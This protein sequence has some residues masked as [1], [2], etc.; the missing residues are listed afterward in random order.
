M[1][2]QDVQVESKES[3]EPIN[4]PDSI[5][6]QTQLNGLPS[7]LPS[8]HSTVQIWVEQDRHNYYLPIQTS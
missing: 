6:P 1:V 4:V 7:S 5:N 8:D 3:N 2:A